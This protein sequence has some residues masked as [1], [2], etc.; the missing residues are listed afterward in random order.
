MEGRLIAGQPDRRGSERHAHP[1]AYGIVR[2]RIRPGYD[3][4]VVDI[5]AGGALIEASHR[6]L[7]GAGVELHFHG[8]GPVAERVRGRVVRLHFRGYP[9]YPG[10]TLSFA[11]TLPVPPGHSLPPPKPG[12][13]LGPRRLRRHTIL[14]SGMPHHSGRL[15]PYCCG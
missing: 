12:H 15:R 7:P 13:W 11:Q 3:V 1:L 9:D 4:A 8:A 5:S 6:L 2:A 14:T 10:H